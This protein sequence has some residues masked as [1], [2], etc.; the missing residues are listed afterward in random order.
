MESIKFGN[1]LINFTTQFTRLWNNKGSPNASPVGF[2][3]PVP[4]ADFLTDYFRLA[5]MQL[6]D[7]AISTRKP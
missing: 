4:S 2:W 5:T 3:R 7:T 6:Q 1:L